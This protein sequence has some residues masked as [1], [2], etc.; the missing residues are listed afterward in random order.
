[1]NFYKQ[2]QGCGL[3]ENSVIVV[4][5]VDN[6]RNVLCHNLEL[7]VSKIRETVCEEEILQ[8]CCR[9]LSFESCA[10]KT[11]SSTMPLNSL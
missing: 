8:L 4:L 5:V 6:P 7:L 11:Y 2:I 3:V 9:Q 10:I 1:M